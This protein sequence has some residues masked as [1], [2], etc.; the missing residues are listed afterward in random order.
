MKNL[1]RRLE[2]LEKRLIRE[3]IL[4][5]MSDG[6]TQSILGDANYLLD[7]MIC[8]LNGETV[9]ELELIAQSISSDE[10]NG[11]H[12]CDMVRLLYGA[13]KRQMQPGDDIPAG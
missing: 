11:A 5:Q 3:P 6:S 13:T 4:L 8:T 10:P 2:R 9:P 1:L 12:M 7:L